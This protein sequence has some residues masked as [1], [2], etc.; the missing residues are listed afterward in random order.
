[1]P[2]AKKPKPAPMS[3]PNSPPATTSMS[4]NTEANEEPVKPE[5][6]TQAPPAAP[7]T[8]KSTVWVHPA[9][10]P[11]IKNFKKFGFPHTDNHETKKCQDWKLIRV[12][13]LGALLCDREEC[14]Y[15]G[16]PPTGRNKIKEFLSKDPPCPGS[17]GR[18]PGKVCWRNCTNTKIRFDIH[19]SGWALLRHQG[20]HDHPWPTPKKPDPEALEELAEEVKK[21][22]KAT[23]LQLKIGNATSSEQP[24]NSV[25][26][27]HESF[28]NTDRLRYYV[29]Q[30][31][32]E[33]E[34]APKMMNGGGGGDGFLHDMFQWHDNLWTTSEEHF[35]FQSEWM[36]QR[37]L[38]R[39]EEGNKL[40]SGGLISDVTYKFFKDGYLLT[41][42][43][44]C[45]EISRWIPVQLSW[46][47]GLSDS[48]Y[49]IHFT[50]LF[51]QFLLPSILPSERED[52]ATSIVD[53]S[54]AQ[55]NGFVAAY[56]NVFGKIDRQKAIA[57]LKGCWEHFC[58][59]ITCVK[60]NRQVIR[61]GEES[62]F[63]V[64]CLAL[65]EQFD[66]AGRT[67]EERIDEVRRL[68]P[69]IKRWLDWWAMAD[70]ANMLFPSCR[71][72]PE[73][74]PEGEDCLPNTTNAQETLPENL[75]RMAAPEPISGAAAGSKLGPGPPSESPTDSNSVAKSPGY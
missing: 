21:N 74:S 46:I 59:S 17:A 54:Q 57:K 38:A 36:S 62:R 24:I 66:E 28:G 37:L 71:P 32:K 10:S 34:E 61:P 23:A 35:T 1:M 75:A 9:D 16:S 53:F 7:E 6:R 50:V 60:G 27:I 65:L 39:S 47:R 69:R 49:E 13:C 67:H 18:C 51:R 22:P 41:T 42:S 8:D 11:E 44:Y 45:E 52:L 19:S 30:I 15:A 40:Y 33:F 25:V 72:M 64:M 29:R 4:N 20:L 68:F 3:A 31:R 56:C 12:T 63:E 58:Q 43:M 2:P 26:D 73:D 55:M 5:V 48:Y 14:D 70:V